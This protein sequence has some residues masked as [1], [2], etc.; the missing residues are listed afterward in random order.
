MFLFLQSTVLR[1]AVESLVQQLVM[2]LIGRAIGEG[3][4]APR[5]AV[6]GTQ[7]LTLCHDCGR[8]VGSVLPAAARRRSQS[9]KR[10]PKRLAVAKR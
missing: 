8:C 4:A 6:D 9:A 1:W 10:R 2:Q 7:A 5:L 3:R